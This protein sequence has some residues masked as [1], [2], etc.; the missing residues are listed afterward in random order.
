MLRLEP[1]GHLSYI[2]IMIIPPQLN[3][4]R[5]IHIVIDY[6][7]SP[8]RWHVILLHSVKSNRVQI[9]T[10]LIDSFKKEELKEMVHIFFF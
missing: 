4:L 7:N 8:F 2:Y 6:W 10:F 1:L 5:V 9:Q 3:K